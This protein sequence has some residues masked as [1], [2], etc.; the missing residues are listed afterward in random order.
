M[1]LGGEQKQ[2][3]QRRE[4][5]HLC[6]RESTHPR[7]AER[8]QLIE[9]VADPREQA[10]AFAHL[11]QLEAMPVLRVFDVVDVELGEGRGGIELV[12]G[13]HAR[14]DAMAPNDIAA[15]I[16]QRGGAV[17]H[18]GGGHAFQWDA[19]AEAKQCL[20]I[21]VQRLLK[22]QKAALPVSVPS[23]DFMTS[24]KLCLGSF[25]CSSERTGET[26]IIVLS[27]PLYPTTFLHY[28]LFHFVI[29]PYHS[30]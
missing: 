1:L 12:G 6:G 15:G 4:I 26:T 30:K 29:I 10:Y 2:F 21:R 23:M 16:F 24:H 14:I 11:R 25:K 9:I 13:L 17:V 8:T 5:V 7:A 20:L 3:R 28:N 18:A 27:S 22:E 19:R